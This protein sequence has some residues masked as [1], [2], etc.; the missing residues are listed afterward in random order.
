MATRLNPYLDFSGNA[1]E[2]MEFYRSVLGGELQVMTFGDVG[3]GG[4]EYPDDGVM[5]AFLRTADGLELM[6]SDGHDPDATGPDRVSLSL[7]G[8]DAQTLP[9]WFQALAEG[10]VVDVPLEEQVWGDTFG[11]VTDRF[12][13]RWLVNVATPAA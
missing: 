4:G 3:G 1:R 6:A 7:S 12:G 2:A 8:D 10:G 11:Q 9:R 13:V 5:H